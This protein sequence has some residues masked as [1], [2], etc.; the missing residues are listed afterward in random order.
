ME[1]THT[2]KNRPRMGF[3][4]LRKS[5]YGPAVWVFTLSRYRAG[6]LLGL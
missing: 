4:I 6:G 3:I 5:P 1:K 2:E